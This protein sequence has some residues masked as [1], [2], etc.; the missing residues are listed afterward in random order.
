M[1]DMRDSKVVGHKSATHFTLATAP[2]FRTHT[3][4]VALEIVRDI[5]NSPPVD[6]GDPTI[7]SF[8]GLDELIENIEAVLEP[9][10][11]EI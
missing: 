10:W 5:G 3:C 2:P 6:T 4:P 8:E 1:S 11:K 7:V 9:G